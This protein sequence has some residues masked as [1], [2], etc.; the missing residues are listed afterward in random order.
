MATVR[1]MVSLQMSDSM[2]SVAQSPL[3]PFHAVPSGAVRH[4]S[5]LFPPSLTEPWVQ[6]LRVGNA[7]KTVV[8]WTISPR[9]CEV[10][11]LSERSRVDNPRHMPTLSICTPEPSPFQHATWPI[12]DPPTPLYTARRPCP[13][14]FALM[15]EDARSDRFAVS[16]GSE[17]DRSPERQPDRAGPHPSRFRS[18]RWRQPLTGGGS[19]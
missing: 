14:E 18:G 17:A 13:S 12:L 19:P 3:I 16:R 15:F 11:W 6:I 2:D 9:G 5:R 8:A 7:E 10:S 1:P 4:D